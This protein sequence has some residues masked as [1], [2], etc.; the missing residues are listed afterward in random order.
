MNERET[1]LLDA[2]ETKGRIVQNG[3]L[4]F[5]ALLAIP[6]LPLLAVRD[7]R[8]IGAGC[9]VA[10]ALLIVWATRRRIGWDV[11]YKGHQVRFENHPIFGERL[12]LDDRR[13]SRGALGFVKTLDGTIEQGEGAG[14]RI[15][16]VSEAGLLR[17]TCRIVAIAKQP[18]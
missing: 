12:I 11:S 8:W 16:S 4:L 17:F 1:V 5:G 9:L 3:V 15:V 6:G 18:R 14:D 10:A 7:A 13:I 2:V